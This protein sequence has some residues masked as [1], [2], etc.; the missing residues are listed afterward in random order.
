MY[1]IL[2]YAGGMSI[3]AVLD[4]IRAFS[5]M[6]GMSKTRLGEMAGVHRNALRDM[7]H[8][9]WSPTANTVRKLESVIPPDWSPT[10]PGADTPTPSEA[11]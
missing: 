2:C 8:P 10:P 1:R 9:T 4:R 3:E 5:R 11:A 7:D 6:P